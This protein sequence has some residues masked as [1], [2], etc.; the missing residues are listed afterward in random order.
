M[1]A[2]ESAIW[3]QNREAHGST[4]QYSIWHS[5][6]MLATFEDAQIRLNGFDNKDVIKGEKDFYAFM[7]TLYQDMYKNPAQYAVP[8]AE[9]D[10]YMKSVDIDKTVA[11]PHRHDAKESKLR[12]KFQQA[13]QFYPDYFWEIGLAADEIC[14]KNY[15]LVISKSQYHNALASLDHAHIKETNGQRLNAL[16]DRGLAVKETG[17]KVH[18][19]CRQYPA[20]FLGLKVL[21]TAPESKYKHLNYLR[22]DYKGRHRAMPEIEDIQATLET[23]HRDTLN[24]LLPLFVTPKTRY[25]LYPLS[26][27]TSGSNWKV[28]YFINSKRIFGF[29][30]GPG[31]LSIGVLFKT[32]ENL[33]RVIKTL[34]ATDPKLL[35]W[36]CNQF[37][38]VFHDC[39]RNKTIMFGKQK[40]NICCGSSGGKMEITNPQKNDV[41][42]CI[43]II[44]LCNGE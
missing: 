29:Y 13:I 33:M 32:P 12:I 2:S 22:L 25:A 16:M 44:K 18:I 23:E 19:S 3:A 24:L 21:L 42:R 37:T 26:N 11:D 17:T 40:K 30:A 34:E 38:E 31:F 8:A 7:K 1:T 27:I 28:D 41:K 35:E 5:I 9:Y 14:N 10:D 20:M 6:M 15:E 36:F 43:E 4:A 39:P